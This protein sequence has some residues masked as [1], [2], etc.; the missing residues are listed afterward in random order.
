[1]QTGGPLII[2][3]NG[4]AQDLQV[5]IV[6]WGYGCASENFP[7]VYARLDVQTDYVLNT[8]CTGKDDYA[9]L[10]SQPATAIGPPP[11][12]RPTVA[13]T[14]FDACAP[15]NPCQNGGKC[16]DEV[17]GFTCTCPSG[18][19]GNTC[20]VDIDNACAPTNPCQNGGE[21]TDEVGG[22]TCTCQNGFSGTNC[23]VAPPTPAPTPAPVLPQVNTVADLQ[24][25]SDDWND[26]SEKRPDYVT[27]EIQF[28]ENPNEVG[29]SLQPAIKSPTD[30]P[31]MTRNIGEYSK[32][33]GGETV[34]E[35]VPLGPNNPS[36]LT[37]ILVDMKGD[38][39]SSGSPGKY[40][41]YAGDKASGNI[42]GR[43]GGGYKVATMSIVSTKNVMAFGRAFYYDS[44]NPDV[45][46]DNA[47]L[48]EAMAAISRE[49]GAGERLISDDWDE[50]ANMLDARPEYLT[51]EIQ[52]D[53]NPGDVGWSLQPA[54]RL[55][56]SGG[57]TASPFAAH[58]IGDYDKV[59]DGFVVERVPLG[60][61]VPNLLSF[62]LVDKNGD[63]LTDGG[64]GRY[65][66]YSGDKSNGK[67]LAEGSG[68]YSLATAVIVSTGFGRSVNVVDELTLE[69]V[70]ASSRQDIDH[71][72]MA[73]GGDHLRRTLRGAI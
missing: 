63:G 22:Y 34:T 30:G 50:W 6:S 69:F 7:G 71:K 42:I 54:V 24:Y 46:D 3:G 5:G 19:G 35:K 62:I 33:T 60:G 4:P 10:C 28:D 53:K 44:V 59:N 72:E 15:K 1:M 29:W 41:I 13:P 36:L 17:G 43:G 64:L 12:R 16:T 45:A 8:L 57:D 20:K 38:G 52:F 40:T 51:L 55:S 2:P 67:I 61:S 70:A 65:T 37:F 32:F 49:D 14:P 68:D 58:N 66:I 47:D 11:T 73:G 48:L 56:S 39:M 31:I 27:V 26:M 9:P 21:C 23:S 25:A 18:W